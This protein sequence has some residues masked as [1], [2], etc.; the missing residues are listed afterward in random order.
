MV[1]RWRAESSVVVTLET[2]QSPLGWLGANVLRNV[3]ILVVSG[4]HLPE[5]HGPDAGDVPR[6]IGWLIAVVTWIVWLKLATLEPSQSPIGWLNAIVARNVRHRLVTP[7][8]A[9]RVED[10]IDQAT[11]E[12]LRDRTCEALP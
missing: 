7:D 5:C 12:V 8:K 1:E 6:L 10:V 11:D 9:G 4:R 3:W 2:S